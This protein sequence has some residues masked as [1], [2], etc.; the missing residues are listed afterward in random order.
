MNR[1]RRAWLLPILS[2]LLVFS[3]AGPLAAACITSASVSATSMVFGTINPF[4]L[5]AD[6]TAIL[7]LSYTNSG[8]ACSANSV[9]TLGL[10][11][12]VGA[13]AA[14][15]KMTSGAN[16]LNYTI[17]TPPGPPTTVWD[18]VTGY[19]TPTIAIPTGTTVQ[20]VTMYGRVLTGQSNAP[21]GTYS[22]TVII[23]V[24]Y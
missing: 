19:T 5:P 13:T 23:T 12:G 7:S 11:T 1:T 17:Y 15:R 24:T 22:D 14:S 2:A 10:G 4:T 20:T 21:I 16:T 6:T 18:N 8:T 9:V 3:A